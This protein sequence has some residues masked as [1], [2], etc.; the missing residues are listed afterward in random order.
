M[1]LDLGSEPEGSYK[2]CFE[3]G[4]NRTKSKCSLRDRERER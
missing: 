4:V 1:F 2:F 3:L